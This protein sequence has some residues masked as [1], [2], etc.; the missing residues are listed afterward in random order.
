[1]TDDSSL[2]PERL[3]ILPEGSSESTFQDDDSLPS[4]PVP[5][6]E[7][8]LSLYV[9][10]LRPLLSED[11]LATSQKIVKDFASSDVAQMLQ[12]KLEEKGRKCRNWM[13]RW[14]DEEV[15]LKFRLPITPFNNMIGIAGTPET[16]RDLDPYCLMNLS[17]YLEHCLRFWKLI[18]EERVRPQKVKRGK[19]MLPLTMH[20]FRRCFNCCQI[21][22]KGMDSIKFHFKT[23]EF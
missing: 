17:C 10:S 7:E 18:R 14:W 19:D 2:D 1:M 13:E 15:Y 3:F 6:L 4:L 22:G 16:V 8:S 9:Q 5:T 12:R 23:S 21:P 20:Q 11:E